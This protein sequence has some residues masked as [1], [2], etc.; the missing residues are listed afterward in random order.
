MSET[1]LAMTIFRDDFTATFIL[2]FTLLLTAKC[3]HWLAQDRVE[4]LEQA[5]QNNR[6]FHIRLVSLMALLLLFDAA[7]VAWTVGDFLE[8]GPSIA[9]MFG[10][11]YMILAANMAN[12]SIK[13]ALHVVDARMDGQW[14]AKS[15][16]AFYAEIFFGTFL[17]HCWDFNYLTSFC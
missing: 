9:I 14:E 1:F 3:F 2:S 15:I 10:F 8:R 13:Y 7:M 17:Y 5:P 4:M 6:W 11:E 16:L 12:A